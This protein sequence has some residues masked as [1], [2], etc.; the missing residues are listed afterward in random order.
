MSIDES[1]TEQ[2]QPTQTA[3]EVDTLR[4]FVK[5]M[6]EESGNELTYYPAPVSNSEA[7]SNKSEASA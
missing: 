6:A 5:P 4:A 3:G 1:A 2:T 7:A